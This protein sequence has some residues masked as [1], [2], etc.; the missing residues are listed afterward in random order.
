MTTFV[1]TVLLPLLMPIATTRGWEPGPLPVPFGEG[2]RADRDTRSTY[3]DHRAA[4]VLYGTA[5]SVTRWHRSCDRMVADP[6]RLTALEWVRVDEHSMTR[7]FMILHLAAVAES[8]P[9]LVSGWSELVRW[10]SNDEAR[11]TTLLG[12]IREV[13]GEQISLTT[14][15]HSPFRV[16]YVDSRPQDTPRFSGGTLGSV[17]DLQFTLGSAVAANSVTPSAKQAEALE[18]SVVHLSKDWSV[19]VL[20]DGA[21]F[22]GNEH[23]NPAFL[24][25]FGA[26]YV[27]SIYTDALLL[28]VIQRS[29]LND[30][31]DR[32]ASL[33]DPAR[34]PRAVERL[35]AEFSRF[36]NRL[37]WQHLTQHGIGNELL[38]AYAAQHRLHELMAET[39]SE[40][41][42]YSRQARL[43]ASRVLNIAVAIL[44]VV[45]ATGVLA[46][47]YRFFVEPP[48]LPSQQTLWS[49]AAV[50]GVLTVVLVS[51]PFGVVSRLL[52]RKDLPYVPRGRRS[53]PPIDRARAR[54]PRRRAA[55]GEP[56]R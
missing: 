47:L 22:V 38:L 44:A 1:G 2:Q 6:I 3:F 21:A 39:R 51:H 25:R 17:A 52:P 7:G 37:W 40:L 12:A 8:L 54:G 31:A 27:R 19:M 14:L 18:A 28:G 41:Q 35:D 26:A 16:A 24:D 32:L 36:R 20:R 50:L 56:E 5:R 45:G 46:D 9:D 34:R 13:V 55:S 49:A 33:G 48:A 29:V 10:K 4:E 15:H 53:A 23:A 11:S 43:R 42:D 30:F